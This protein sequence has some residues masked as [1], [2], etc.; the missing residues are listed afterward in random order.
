[1]WLRRSNRRWKVVRFRPQ[2]ARLK[3]KSYASPQSTP[4]TI[5]Q[6]NCSSEWAR[7]LRAYGIRSSIG[8]CLIFISCLVALGGLRNTKY[9]TGRSWPLDAT[10]SPKCM[11]RILAAFTRRRFLVRH[12]ESSFNWL[13]CQRPS[14]HKG[15]GALA[16]NGLRH[17]TGCRSYQAHFRPTATS[18]AVIA[19]PWR[20]CAG[21]L[22][23]LGL[24]GGRAYCVI[25]NALQAYA[26]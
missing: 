16:V 14:P 10:Q 6:G 8:T 7:E 15:E 25:H 12:G 18:R 11:S 13:I 21:R 20:A 22:R 24:I 19:T 4:S 1:M 2:R 3:L 17:V 23:L 9:E 5:E 26:A